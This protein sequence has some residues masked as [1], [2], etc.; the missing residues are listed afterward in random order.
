[1]YYSENNK[2]AL[3]S[4]YKQLG[5]DNLLRELNSVQKQLCENY[6]AR[7]IIDRINTIGYYN[8][9]Y[10]LTEVH[11]E[12]SN[13]SFTVKSSITGETKVVSG[14]I[15]RDYLPNGLG[16]LAL[17]CADDLVS[18]ILYVAY[19][20]HIKAFDE[21]VNNECM[22]ARDLVNVV[23]AVNTDE[24]AI[25]SFWMNALVLPKRL[26]DYLETKLK[27]RYFNEVLVDNIKKVL[28]VSEVDTNFLEMCKTN[29]VKFIKDIRKKLISV[30]DPDMRFEIAGRLVT[31]TELYDGLSN[32]GAIDLNIMANASLK[33]AVYVHAPN[34]DRLATLRERSSCVKELFKKD[35]YFLAPDK[36][37]KLLYFVWACYGNDNL[38]SKFSKLKSS[39]ITS[40]EVWEVLFPAIQYLRS[41]EFLK[42]DIL[43]L[44]EGLKEIQYPESAEDEIDNKDFREMLEKTYNGYRDRRDSYSVMIQDICRKAL[45]KNR[46]LSDKQISVVKK[47]YESLIKNEDNTYNKY[48]SSIEEKIKELLDFYDYDSKSF[49]Y[50]IL[51]QVLAN[52]RCSIKQ[53][54]II[55]D[56]YDK[57]LE[58]KDDIIEVDA[59]DD[60]VSYSKE[61]EIIEDDADT[62][63]EYSGDK[64]E[65]PD[66]EELWG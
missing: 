40:N 27:F 64:I 59:I 16:S 61:S 58:R 47:A 65:I 46:I 56:I 17:S 38:I 9:D 66:I 57:Y 36:R 35:I 52:K 26:R 53:L 54:N 51:T 1:M 44:Q 11:L 34:G 42:V 14:P 41:S 18:D 4:I 33:K 13:V 2:V 63:V 43:K 48:D 23:K 8:A 32:H 37:E 45:K 25:Y 30:T 3:D 7:Y 21:Y 24:I 31:F 5:K 60:S 62:E 6:V 15:L 39:D 49:N 22:Y 29:N 19:I 12:D 50:K 20:N 28:N 10:I 55:N